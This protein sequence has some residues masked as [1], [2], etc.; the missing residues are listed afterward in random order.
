M[1]TTI[2]DAYTKVCPPMSGWSKDQLVKCKGPGCMWWQEHG[3][4]MRE[5]WLDAAALDGRTQQIYAQQN[6]LIATHREQHRDGL[7]HW[8]FME[9]TGEPQG[10]CGAAER[11]VLVET[12]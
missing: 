2:E 12:T 8:L 3:N 4:V 5:V 1:I 11:D 7:P 10:A 6:G 9:D